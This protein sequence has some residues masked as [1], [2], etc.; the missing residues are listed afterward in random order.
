MIEDLLLD[1]ASYP[2]GLFEKAALRR[3]YERH[4]GGEDLTRTLWHL[5]SLQLWRGEHLHPHFPLQARQEVAIC[6]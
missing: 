5:L 4:L 1:G 3:L 6:A 2:E